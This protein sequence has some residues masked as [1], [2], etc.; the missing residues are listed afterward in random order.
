HAGH[1]RSLVQES[2]SALD[3]YWKKLQDFYGSSARPVVANLD[4]EDGLE[5]LKP[6]LVPSVEKWVEAVIQQLPQE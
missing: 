2:I 5:S 4:G 1:S 3:Q 6:A